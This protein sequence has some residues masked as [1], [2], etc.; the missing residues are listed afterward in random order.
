[1]VVFSSETPAVLLASGLVMRFLYKW[2][3]RRFSSSNTS[4]RFTY[5]SQEKFAPPS[6]CGR[7][8]VMSMT[9]DDLYFQCPINHWMMQFRH[10][11]IIPLV[12]GGAYV[13]RGT[14]R[15]FR[16]V[17]NLQQ[18][19][20][21]SPVIKTKSEDVK[22]ALVDLLEAKLLQF[23]KDQLKVS[24]NVTTVLQYIDSPDPHDKIVMKQMLLDVGLILLAYEPHASRLGW[25]AWLVMCQNYINSPQN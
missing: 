8:P 18:A 10:S 25:G 22:S 13:L 14:L 23:A 19:M 15:D 21:E 12:E 5:F 16:D 20:R 11:I 24:E 4:I 6:A 9:L 17:K 2:Y 7:L 3:Q 1:M